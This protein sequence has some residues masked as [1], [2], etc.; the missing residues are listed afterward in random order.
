MP[1]TPNPSIEGTRGAK[2][3]Q[4]R[5]VFLDLNGTLVLPLKQESLDEMTLI[6][7]ADLAVMRL[8]AAGFI[9]PVV[10]VQARIAKGLF[11]EPE[12]RAWFANF[13]GNLGLAVKGPYICPHRYNHSCPCQK[14]NSFLYDRAASDWSI[15]LRT[16]YTIGDSPQDV[17]AA[18][19]FG[20]T[21]CV[22]RTGWAAEDKFLDEARPFAAFIGDSIS[23]A[24]EWIVNREQKNS[25]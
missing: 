21:G 16:S 14:P 17:E 11:S 10:T 4:N 13:F 19:R 20:G 9:C 12:F 8:L 23:D 5:A 3:G 22:V 18:R 24:V 15:D 6:P 1:Q 25:E 2:P 7:G